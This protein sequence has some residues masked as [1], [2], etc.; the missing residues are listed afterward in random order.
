MASASPSS[1]FFTNRTILITGGSSG[2]GLALAERLL[3]A[4]NQVIIVGR[5]TELLQQIKHRLPAIHIRTA[6]VSKAEDRV[7]LAEWATATFPKLDVLI[8]NAGIFRKIDLAG[9][10]QEQWD[11]TRQELQTNL[12][13]PIHL[14]QLLV[15]H[16]KKQPSAALANVSSVLGFVPFAAGPVYSASKA[17]LHSFTLSLRYQ[18]RDTNIRVIEIVPPEVQTTIG[19]K[20]PNGAPLD[21]YADATIKSL[22]DNELEITFGP[23]G[24]IT[25]AGRE[26]L[27]R[28]FDAVQSA[29]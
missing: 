4:G 16:L 3:G 8:N 14:T 25:R 5:R 18:L 6:D 10:D 26:H 11:D 28:A 12:E 20:Q 15:R 22:N 1:L 23:F 29:L 13:A 9:D 17:A 21:E 27:D 7:Q 19:G 24:A 2:I